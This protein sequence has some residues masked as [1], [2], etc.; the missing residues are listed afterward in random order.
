MKPAQFRIV[1][2]SK[3]RT[4][5]RDVGPWDQ[6][7]TVT[8]DVEGVVERIVTFGFLYPGARL[9][10]YDSDDNRAEILVKDEKFAGFKSGAR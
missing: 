8:N 6:F 3:E 2:T 7:P 5:I 1:S 9:F 4:V 10:Y